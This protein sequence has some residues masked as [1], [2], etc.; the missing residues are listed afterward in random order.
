[1]ELIEWK[2][3]SDHSVK[4]LNETIDFYRYFDATRQAEFLFGCVFDTINRIFPGEVD[5]ILKYDEFKRFID[6]KY[7]MPDKLVATLV[8]FLE[9]NN[10]KLSKRARS[11]EFSKLQDE[12]VSRIEEVFREVFKD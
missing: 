8:R 12:E 1:M 5:Y 6:D 7:E 9:Q 3:T 11:K 10:G 4:V 2:S